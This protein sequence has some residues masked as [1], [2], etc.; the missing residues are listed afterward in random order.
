MLKQNMTEE[1]AAVLAKAELIQDQASH[2]ESDPQVKELLVAAEEAGLD[3]LSVLQALREVLS[4]QAQKNVIEYKQ[5]ELVF[6][7]SN[8]GC[9]YPAFIESVEKGSV[10][11]KFANG[12]QDRL[13]AE[14]IKPFR[15]APGAKVEFSSASTSWYWMKGEVQRFNPDTRS[16]ALSYWGSEQLIPLEKI[17]LA[18][19]PIRFSLSAAKQSVFVMLGIAAGSGLLGLLL[20]LLISR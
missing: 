11:V 15:M 10:V 20:G 13:P 17:R 19:E 18:K 16:T 2:L 14:D 3:R 6:A 1:M 7:K 4:D 9:S 12:A 8:D 5:G